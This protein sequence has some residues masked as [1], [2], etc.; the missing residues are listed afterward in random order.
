[1]VFQPVQLCKYDIKVQDDWSDLVLAENLKCFFRDPESEKRWGQLFLTSPKH[2]DFKR[3]LSWL[4][5]YYPH[6][7]D[8]FDDGK[9]FRQIHTAGMPGPAWLENIA[10]AMQ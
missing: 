8:N 5:Q 3:S 2:V 9:E 10:E 7:Q 6:K 1:M 4:F